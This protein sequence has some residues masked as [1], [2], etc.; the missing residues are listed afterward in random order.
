MSV[1]RFI[2]ILI[3]ITIIG[4]ALGFFTQGDKASQIMAQH[5]ARMAVENIRDGAVDTRETGR[6]Y[7][8]AMLT[9]S[10]RGMLFNISKALVDALNEMNY[11]MSV[12]VSGGTPQNIEWLLQNKG[13]LAIVNSEKALQA[14]HAEGPFKDQPPA[15]DLRVLM[16]LW[17]NYWQ[18]M[19][20]ADSGINT[21]A[22]LQGKKIAVDERYSDAYIAIQALFKAAGLNYDEDKIIFASLR[23]SLEFITKG[24][25][26]VIFMI[27]MLDGY[28]MNRINSEKM[29]LKLVPIDGDVFQKLSM[30]HPYY[31]HDVFPAQRVYG[32]A[33]DVST[34]STVN[35]LLIAKNVPD[36]IVIKLLHNLWDNG[37]AIQK[38][39]PVLRTTVFDENPAYEV[40]LPYHPGGRVGHSFRCESQQTGCAR[41]AVLPVTVIALA[42]LAIQPGP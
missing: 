39:Y 6:S 21:L 8:L 19:T 26:D 32:M 7:P 42:R 18:I 25:C 35:L 36:D 2:L 41:P 40:G 12:K 10:S 31:L 38:K 23:E 34:V 14:Y 4:F 29:N 30:E 20:L 33:E 17:G 1:K 11:E 3:V 27:A 37:E 22:D 16:S 24:E 9:G 13:Q 28:R 15:D 5:K